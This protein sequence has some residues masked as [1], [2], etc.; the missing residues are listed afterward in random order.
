MLGLSYLFR[1]QKNA[2]TSIYKAIFEAFYVRSLQIS[3]YS[4]F[5]IESYEEFD[6]RYVETVPYWESYVPILGIKRSHIGTKN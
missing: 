4:A 5:F 3:Y 1:G 6:T 2:T